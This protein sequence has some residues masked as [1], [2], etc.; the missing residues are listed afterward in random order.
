MLESF[1]RRQNKAELLSNRN[2]KIL[3]D[4]V[5]LDIVNCLVDF[6][7]EAF[8]KG[9]PYNIDKEHK[10]STARAAVCLFE[11]LKSNDPMN[12]TVNKSRKTT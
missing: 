2:V 4:K 9:N 8:G 11:G 12:E 7:V 5:R 6:A 1:F 3:D 10:K